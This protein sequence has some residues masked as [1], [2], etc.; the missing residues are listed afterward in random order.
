MLKGLF[1]IYTSGKNEENM[2][3]LGYVVFGH[4]KIVCI[5]GMLKIAVLCPPFL[6]LINVEGYCWHVQTFSP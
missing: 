3:A 6:Q 1:I 5:S 2:L 4:L